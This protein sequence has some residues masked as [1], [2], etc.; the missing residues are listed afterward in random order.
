MKILWLLISYFIQSLLKF[1]T[2]QISHNQGSSLLINYSKQ[3]HQCMRDHVYTSEPY[4]TNQSTI[5]INYNLQIQL[6]VLINYIC[7]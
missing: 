6:T 3:G 5:N 2:Q 1:L 7:F 4:V